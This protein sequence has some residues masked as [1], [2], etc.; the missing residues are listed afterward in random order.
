MVTTKQKLIVNTQKIKRKEYNHTTKKSH[1]TMKEE[2][3]R[4]K[5]QRGTI[6]TIRKQSTKWK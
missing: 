4:R 1:Q 2:S 6:K 5:E 3:R